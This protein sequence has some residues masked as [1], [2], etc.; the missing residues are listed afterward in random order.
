M[1]ETER[2]LL[3]P[4]RAEDAEAFRPIATDPEVMRYITGGKPWSD[5][6]IQELVSAGCSPGATVRGS[7]SATTA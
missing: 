1:L 2:L 7:K 4:W 3:L 6:Q 5:E